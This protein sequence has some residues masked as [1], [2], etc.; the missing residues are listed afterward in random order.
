M[1]LSGDTSKLI[2]RLIEKEKFYLFDADGRVYH[3]VVVEMRSAASHIRSKRSA[4][5]CLDKR[6]SRIRRESCLWFNIGNE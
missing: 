5:Q 1:T 2:V 6:S 3:N 4:A